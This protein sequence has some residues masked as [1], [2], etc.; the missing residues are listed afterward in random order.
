VVGIPVLVTEMG[1]GSMTQQAF[2][3]SLGKVGGKWGEFAGWWG[4]LNA[5]FITMY[6]ITILAWVVGMFIGA[7]GPLW[8]E[9]TALPAF[10]GVGSLAN[11][12]GF[13]FHMLSSGWVLLLVVLVWLLNL[14]I[15]RRGIQTIEP[16]VKVF[17]P[18]MWLFM[19]I[20]I[21]RGITLPHG[22]EG[23]FLLFTPD[24]EIMRD[25]GV[26]RGAA[27]QI[28]FSLTLGFGVMTAYASYLPRDADQ[29]NNGVVTACLN[30][31]FEFLA[32]LAIFSLL[33]TFAVVPQ[34]STLAMMFFVVPEGISAMPAG[35]TLFGLVFF[36]LL[37]M[38][39]LSSSISLIEGLCCA[40]IDKF[41]WPRRRVL[42]VAC[43]V[44]GVGS[45]L[46]A[47]P[48]V[49]DRQIASNGTLGLSLLDLMDHWA[50]EHGLLIVG[51]VECLILG[52]ML[53]V[54]KLREH[55]N[56]HSRFHLPAAF[57]W[58][59]KLV[60]PAALATVLGMSVYDKVVGGIYGAN[61]AFDSLRGLPQGVLAVWLLG[62]TGLALWLTFNRSGR[63]EA[64]AE[65][66][67]SRA[68]EATRAETTRA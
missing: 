1:L 4:L 48:V 19:I 67:A 9:E 52:W 25:P 15:V 33:F 18:L 43:L 66:P 49:V 64:V 17:V 55:L 42:A 61:M 47:L 41:A 63:Q 62:T 46:F 27:S 50:F 60:I 34:A 44:G 11:P 3:A 8:K 10:P 32:G 53:P 35:V 37:L 6:Y 36:L 51:L 54:E 7:F 28:F 39:G 23:I 56:R 5:T 38:A 12:D 59:I 29:I 14:L 65:A 68:P 30:C 40:I 45:L 26:W 13:F 31:S 57:N 24:F 20:L 2:P 22:E 58:L 21:V 16:A